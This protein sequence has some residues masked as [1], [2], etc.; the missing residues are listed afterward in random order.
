M[1]VRSSGAGLGEGGVDGEVIAGRH[2][3][4]SENEMRLFFVWKGDAKSKVG[5]YIDRLSQPREVKPE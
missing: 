3:G 4:S 5:C 1:I 2:D